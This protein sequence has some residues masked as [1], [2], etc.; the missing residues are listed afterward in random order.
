RL[1]LSGE[2]EWISSRQLEWIAKFDREQANL[3]EAM[4]FCVSD[5]P[6]AGLT[7]AAALYPYWLSR[8]SVGEGRR[9]LDRL[10][11]VD[12]GT[13]TLGRAKGLF[14]DSVL[15][16]VQGDLEKGADLV[17]EGHRLGPH[18]QDPLAQDL[19]NL[20]AGIL[21]LFSND[22]LQACPILEDAV[23]AFRTRDTSALQVV[24]LDSLGVA[25]ELRGDPAQALKCY[26]QVR[27]ITESCGEVVYRSQALCSM[28]VAVWI[29]G[30]CVRATSLLGQ[31]LELSQQLSD[32]MT[33]AA[34]LE[35]LAWITAQDDVRRAAVLM[36]AADEL[37][38][39]VGCVPVMFPNRAVHHEDCIRAV[40]R[41]LGLKVF[42]DGLRKGR[43]LDLDSAIAYAL[44]TTSRPKSL[45]D[46]PT[47]LT[48]RERQVAELV[49]EGLTNRKIADRLVISQRTAQGH[50]EHVLTKLGFTSRAQIAAWITEQTHR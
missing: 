41:A 12:A 43:V 27:A 48:K 46:A 5:N 42:E 6:E 2:A 9:W 4:E 19:I 14:A 31:C 17:A 8:G 16:V 11:S 7:I 22:L 50:V 47:N 1:A 20:A 30:D 37:A 18:L 21:A 28:A 34:C 10:L 49:A 35:L 24:A 32:R 40:R 44:G 25:Y 45:A 26:E 38:R 13:P 3:R 23:E 29:Q 15:A 33:A 36:G 39:S